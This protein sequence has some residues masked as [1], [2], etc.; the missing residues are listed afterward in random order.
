[1]T[2]ERERCIDDVLHRRPGA[3][4][5]IDDGCLGLMVCELFDAATRHRILLFGALAKHGLIVTACCCA[6]PSMELTP[7]RMWRLLRS[8]RFHRDENTLLGQRVRGAAFEEACSRRV[9]RG[10]SSS[11]QEGP[12]N[13][14]RNRLRI[15][16][17]R[18]EISVR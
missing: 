1:M 12:V 7:G 10:G 8:R 16:A 3:N 13:P 17:S 5:V 11:A 14:A 18:R 15:S 6:F 2:L 9:D 4:P